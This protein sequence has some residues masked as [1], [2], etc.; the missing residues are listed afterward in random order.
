MLEEPTKLTL[1][2]ALLGL[3]DTDDAS[4]GRGG[5]VSALR[6]SHVGMGDTL[7]LDE[8]QLEG[9]QRGAQIHWHSDSGSKLAFRTAID[10]QGGES[11][12]AALRVLPGSHLRSFEEMAAE[13]N[14]LDPA[15]KGKVYA[16]HPDEVE[17]ALDRGSTLVWTPTTWHATELQRTAKSRRAFG[18]NFNEH[19]RGTHMRDLAAVKY[20]FAGEWEKWPQARQRLWGLLDDPEPG[21][22]L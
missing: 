4:V 2:A 11:G 19:K 15:A 5:G 9:P 1:A 7:T 10:A 12:N 21:S 14:R 8:M 20:V 3:D 6:I 17:V 13:F 22:R 18:W 16:T